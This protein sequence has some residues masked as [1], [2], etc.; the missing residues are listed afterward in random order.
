[1]LRNFSF[2]SVGT[3]QEKRRI[4]MGDSHYIKMEQTVDHL[5]ESY[6]PGKRTSL[7]ADEI[8]I[9][10]S[11]LMGEGTLEPLYPIADHI[12]LQYSPNGNG[13]YE[14]K[15]IDA[16]M[17]EYNDRDFL[18][19]CGV[20][21]VF[22]QDVYFIGRTIMRQHNLGNIEPF[23][24]DLEKEKLSL[25]YQMALAEMA[26]D[27]SYVGD[28]SALERG[29]ILRKIFSRYLSQKREETLAAF[30]G[31][32]AL[33]RWFALTVL[34][35]NLDENKAEIL[36][37][38][39][40]STNAVRNRLADIL[41]AK[42]EWEADIKKLALSK[43]LGERELAVRV[44][45]KWQTGGADYTEI[46]SE[47]LEKEK[48]AKL[49][50]L[51]QDTLSERENIA[52]ADKNKASA[53]ESAANGKAD[54]CLSKTGTANRE[55]AAASKADDVSA[56]G[57]VTAESLIAKMHKGN[58]KRMLEWAYQ[59]PFTT[60][61]KNDG[62]VAGDDYMQ[63]FLLCYSTSDEYGII[64]DASILA[65]GLKED[66]LAAFVNELYDRWLA[67]GAEAKKRWVLYAASI[68]G[69]NA[70][71]AKIK[72]QIDEWAQNER[73][74]IAM[75]AVDA[76]ALNP[77]QDTL[78][79]IDNM[80]RK[81]K[82]K[83]VKSAAK[84]ALE[85][86]ASRLGLTGEELADRMIPDLGFDEN[87]ERVFDYGARK[88]K[89]TITPALEIEVFD[90]TGKK[91]KNLP[92][93]NKK[94]DE[95]LGKA[96][97]D[98]FKQMKKQIKLIAGNQKSRLEYALMAKREWT[99]QAWKSLFVKN[100]IMHQFATGLIWGVYEEGKLIQSFRYME[101]GSFNTEDEEEYTLPEKKMQD[102]GQQ[103]NAQT[104]SLVH[105]IELTDVSL[106]KW[107]Q[108][109][110][111]YEIAQ[112]IEQLCRPFYRISEEERNQKY[113][114]RF[115]GYVMNE[116]YLG[117]K[118]LG[119]GWYRGDV[120]D[121]GVFYTY[122]REETEIGFGAEL[123]MSGSSILAGRY[124]G[125]EDVTLYEVR[126]YRAGEAYKGG[127]SI[128][129][130]DI[131]PRYFSEIV[132]QLTNATAASGSKDEGWRKNRGLDA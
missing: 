12:K 60:V 21:Y 10:K 26:C 116:L 51:L 83:A 17:D 84:K 61:H 115:G 75:D 71:A 126:F 49:I 132:L 57:V 52:M 78:L 67:L 4:T 15:F 76:L 124:G 42:K 62:T 125:T 48:N 28:P 46:L 18:R 37:Y 130:K 74:S 35:Q 106:S 101:D 109:L 89:V 23:F 41:Y 54:S 122:Y 32:G 111:D 107:K 102:N 11:Y 16:F 100:P 98:E 87:M 114:E 44:L 34:E 88:F 69:K 20:F 80:S 95:A 119:M 30:H 3:I 2:E 14:F 131:P 99:A 29:R 66:E 97:L 127:M 5:L 58:R 112:P 85:N 65:D 70:I 1:M 103:S 82:S 105:P 104:I 33:G 123:Y 110:E 81:H 120:E 55:C 121:G 73:T 36:S 19:R 8:A 77:A 92:A 90:E 39:P 108:Q 22:R 9:I 47:M 72:R 38:A 7:P 118:L 40:D 129:P 31:A 53:Q 27:A 117:G 91:L 93:V 94:D 45:V 6:R 13:E 96:A 59:T 68:Y 50:K 64:K 56:A 113:L 86:A 79:L 63:A 128:P 43:K 25:K 24:E